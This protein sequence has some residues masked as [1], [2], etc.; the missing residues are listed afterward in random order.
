MRNRYRRPESKV[1]QA[2]LTHRLVGHRIWGRFVTQ[3]YC[4][5]DTLNQSEWWGQWA[6]MRLEMWEGPVYEAS[7]KVW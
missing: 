7:V 4:G 6:G 2:Q 3:H 1:G 5:T